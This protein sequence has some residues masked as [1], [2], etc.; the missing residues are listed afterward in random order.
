MERRLAGTGRLAACLDGENSILTMFFSSFPRIFSVAKNPPIMMP[1]FKGKSTPSISPMRCTFTV[2]H[3]PRDTLASGPRGPYRGGPGPALRLAGGADG[4][5]A[6]RRGVPGPAG[7]QWPGHT[8]L[9]R[10]QK[11]WMEFGYI[12]N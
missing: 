2:T 9:A 4:G 1:C 7:Y 10:T 6:P 3:T 8:V 5:P 12:F 11:G